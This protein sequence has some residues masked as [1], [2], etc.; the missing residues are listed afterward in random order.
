MQSNPKFIK[1]QPSSDIVRDENGKIVGIHLI[2]RPNSVVADRQWCEAN[3]VDAHYDYLCIQIGSDQFPIGC[4][5]KYR[6]PDELYANEIPTD[7]QIVE[8]FKFCCGL[9]GLTTNKNKTQ[10]FKDMLLRG[11]E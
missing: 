4:V 10:D 9:L 11:N 7:E 2:F 3:S 6:N 8:C 5:M 1:I